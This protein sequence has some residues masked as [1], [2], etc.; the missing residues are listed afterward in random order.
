MPFDQGLADRVREIL[1]NEAD[2]TEKKMFGGC[3]FLLAGNMCAG[4]E[5]DR[6]VTRVPITQYEDALA[7]PNVGPFPGHE[8]RMRAW[9]AV[10]P[11]GIAEDED[12]ARWVQSGVAVARALPPK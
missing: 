1:A 4:V 3:A 5:R 12:L 11:D 6:L 8:R 2:L 7:Q 10:E 9:V